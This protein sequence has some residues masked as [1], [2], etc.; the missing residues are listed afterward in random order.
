MALDQ[1]TLQTKI[2]TAFEKAKN[3]PP[4]AD[5]ND[6]DTVQTQIVT[7]LAADL[8]AAIGEFVQSGDISGVVTEVTND[9]NVHLG[10]G[11]QTNTV[12]LA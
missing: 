11:I 10:T 12:H 1:M 4:P 6:A 3:T 5:P 8:A 9:A 2:K 7:T